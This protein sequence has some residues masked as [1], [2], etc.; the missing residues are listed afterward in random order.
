MM[1]KS[2]SATKAHNIMTSS[3]QSAP[4]GVGGGKTLQYLLFLARATSGSMFMQALQ[5]GRPPVLQRVLSS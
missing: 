1:I 3:I 2:M 4:G 5:D